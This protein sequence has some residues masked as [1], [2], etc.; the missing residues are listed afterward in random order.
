MLFRFLNFLENLK[1]AYRIAKEAKE[2]F[3]GWNIDEYFDFVIDYPQHRTELESLVSFFMTDYDLP[4]KAAQKKAI[5][6]IKTRYRIGGTNDN[7]T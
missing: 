6:F 2:N 4:K 5:S 3:G 1:E 7:R